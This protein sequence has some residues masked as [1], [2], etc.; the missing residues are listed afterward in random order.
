MP[1]DPPPNVDCQHSNPEF[2]RTFEFACLHI[3]PSYAPFHVVEPFL[4]LWL[5]LRTAEDRVRW[6]M[7]IALKLKFFP[8][9]GGRRNSSISQLNNDAFACRAVTSALFAISLYSSLSSLAAVHSARFVTPPLPLVGG[10]LRGVRRFDPVVAKRS[11][12]RMFSLLY[13]F[14]RSSGLLCSRRKFRVSSTQ[15]ISLC[16]GSSINSLSSV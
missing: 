14:D 12:C 13:W 16:C 6:L 4:P 3:L 8:L 7:K 1:G 15:M 11:P 9:S 2:F 10:L 5:H